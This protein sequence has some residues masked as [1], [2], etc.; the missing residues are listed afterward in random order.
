MEGQEKPKKE[1]FPFPCPTPYRGFEYSA[2]SKQKKLFQ[3]CKAHVWGKHLGPIPAVAWSVPHYYY[4]CINCTAELCTIIK[5]PLPK[6]KESHPV[7]DH[8]M[9]DEIGL[10]PNYVASKCKKCSY[11]MCTFIGE[12]FF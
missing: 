1:P 8:V 5:I 7:C 9:E 3:P 12:S 10:G 11:Q 2:M 4:T 6:R